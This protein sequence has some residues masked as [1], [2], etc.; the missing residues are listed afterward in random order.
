MGFE[1]W[2]VLGWLWLVLC[3][4]IWGALVV[5][6]PPLCALTA[7]APLVLVMYTGTRFVVRK[8]ERAR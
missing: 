5:F 2:I 4:A 7:F 8:I 6:T 1:R 3:C